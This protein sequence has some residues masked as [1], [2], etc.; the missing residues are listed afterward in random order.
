MAEGMAAMPDAGP[1]APAGGGREAGP[2]LAGIAGRIAGRRGG[3]AA[4]YALDARLLL[5]MALGRAEAVLP[6]ETVALDGP[7]RARLKE[8]VRRRAG[9]EPVS[10]IRGWREFHSLRFGIT[11]AVLDPRPDSEVLVDAAAAWLSGRDGARVLD[12]GTGS[13]CLLLS[14]LHDRPAATGLGVDS[15]PGA[16]DCARRNA[17]ALGLAGRAG[18]RLADWDRG[19]DGVFGAVLANPP[20][21]PEP[22]MAG[23][24]PEVR[25]HDPAAA[26]AAGPDGLDAYRAAL[27]AAARRLA[28][29]GRAFVEIGDG[30]EGAVEALAGA[31]GLVRDGLLA[32][33]SGTPRCLVLR[34][35]G[36]T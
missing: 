30:R 1:A 23:L 36:A 8:L 28:A 15:S 7:G 22:D 33:L 24:M 21:I 31:S 17:D 3:A 6:H 4:D 29:D 35:S 10:R 19:L 12:L 32:D 27:P 5:G 26:L 2:L 18:F 14:V 16:V 25:D 20:Y 11:P 13:G 34:H 9:G